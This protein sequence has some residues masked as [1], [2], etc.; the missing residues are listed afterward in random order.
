MILFTDTGE[1]LE[2][3]DKHLSQTVLLPQMNSM[4]GANK[5]FLQGGRFG[6]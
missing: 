1:E 4:S 3:F 6:K 2:S 5:P